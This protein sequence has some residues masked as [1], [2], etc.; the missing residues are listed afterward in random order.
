MVRLATLQKEYNKYKEGFAKNLVFDASGSNVKKVEYQPL[1]VVHIYFNTATYDE[2]KKDV[3]VTL[4]AQLG[5]IG[6][7]MGLFAGFSIFSGVEIVYFV[8]KFLVKVLFKK[9]KSH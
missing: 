6:G 2:V 4:E 9:K 3:K 8:L 1:K 5:V 7:T